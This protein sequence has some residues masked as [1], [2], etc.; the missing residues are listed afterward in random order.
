MIWRPAVN[1]HQLRVFCE[2]ANA[3]S[4]TAAA[5]KLHLTQPAT[6]WQVKRLEEAYGVRLLD[7]AGKRIALTEEG[8]VLL[9]FAGRLLRLAKETDGALADLRGLPMGA[10]RVDAT[11][12]V[13]D[14]Y[15]PGLLEALHRQHPGLAFQIGIG[16]SS[17]VIENTLAQRN[18]I[19]ICAHD[20]VHP[21]LEARRILTDVLV[22][23]VG[24]THAFARRR[25]I[26]L[27]ELA[28][29]PLILR[30]QGSSPRRTI[31]DILARRGI[32]PRVVVESASTPIIKRFAANG[33]GIG[34]LS[35]RVVAKEL[36]E[37]LLR[38]VPF[39][40]AEMKYHFYL[41]RHRDRWA[42]RSVQAFVE[43]AQ[44]FQQEPQP[45]RPRRPNRQ[46]AGLSP[47]ST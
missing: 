28:G 32:T 40:D 34:I 43:M 14:Y 5:A 2:V 9:D 31:D 6:T 45:A 17:Q 7:R 3:R 30:E 39:K 23:V 4:F 47:A 35:E 36:E 25:G 37:G 18:D 11:Y 41:I 46:P 29:Q 8:K 1:L 42:S 21:K 44:A 38:L 19:G 33:A 12:I 22:A 15:L 13:G 27:R 16:N 10:L 26:A 20:P 24:P